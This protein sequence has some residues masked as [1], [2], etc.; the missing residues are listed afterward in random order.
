[1]EVKV[2]QTFLAK[3][4]I[5][6]YVDLHLLM[7]IFSVLLCNCLS[8]PTGAVLYREELN[9]PKCLFSICCTRSQYRNSTIIWLM[10]FSLPP[11]FFIP[12]LRCSWYDY[13][14][15]SPQIKLFSPTLPQT[16]SCRDVLV[17]ACMFYKL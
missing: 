1:M 13:D 4:V 8:L 14:P 6:L 9:R 3:V 17:V 5:A 10:C 11:S 12:P 2:S 15:R 16:P 7:H